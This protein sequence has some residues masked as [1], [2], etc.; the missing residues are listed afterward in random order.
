MSVNHI[1][2]S[3]A[4]FQVLSQHKTTQPVAA[5]PPVQASDSG[6][7]AYAD[8]VTISP[9]ARRL[10]LQADITGNGEGIEPPKNILGNGEGIE[11]PKVQGN[12][13]GI[14]PPKNILGNG[15]GI[16]PP[17]NF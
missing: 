15:E 13:E 9:E 7:Q 11:P 3:V 1:N 4:Q 6:A 8:V 12:G 5:V 10:Q 17:I 16:E 14:E 2:N